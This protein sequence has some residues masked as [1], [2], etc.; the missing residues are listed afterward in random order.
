MII[1][2]EELCERCKNNSKALEISQPFLRF[3]K[4]NPGV[5]KVNL[6]KVK[7]IMSSGVTRGFPQHP[8][9]TSTVLQLDLDKPSLSLTKTA[10]KTNKP[11]NKSSVS[12]KIC[13]SHILKV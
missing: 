9:T 3:E 2:S 13:F 11:Q 12:S 7:V 4:L 10:L 6:T 1:K 8:N 5:E